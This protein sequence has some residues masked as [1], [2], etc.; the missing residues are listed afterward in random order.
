M[1]TWFDMATVTQLQKLLNCFSFNVSTK[2]ELA[3]TSVTAG[4]QLINTNTVDIIQF[5]IFILYF[6]HLL[7][8]L[9]F[10]VN[11]KNLLGRHCMH[12]VN[13]HTPIMW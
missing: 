2:S 1:A 7:T 9:L 6:I 8:Y 3:K 10:S 12:N 5:D 4:N 13:H 11:D